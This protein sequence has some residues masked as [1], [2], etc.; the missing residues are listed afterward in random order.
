MY[1]GIVYITCFAIQCAFSA[2]GWAGIR[3][4]Y[5]FYSKQ[6]MIFFMK[7]TKGDANAKDQRKKTQFAPGSIFKYLPEEIARKVRDENKIK[8]SALKSLE[9]VT[10]YSYAILYKL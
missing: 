2:V 5:Y 9:F 10:N 7:G 8:K 6:D 1:T 4:K 3:N